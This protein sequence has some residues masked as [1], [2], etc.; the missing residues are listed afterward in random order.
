MS[1]ETRIAILT[2]RRNLLNSRDPIANYHIVRKIEREIRR[3][4]KD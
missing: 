3:L 2:A 1:N 4:S